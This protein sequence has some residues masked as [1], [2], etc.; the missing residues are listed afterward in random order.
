MK[1]KVN[2]CFSW[3]LMVVWPQP[4]ILDSLIP[5]Y[6]LWY[7]KT[8]IM[9]KTDK[10][11]KE[12]AQRTAKKMGIPFSAMLNESMREFV[13]KQQITFRTFEDVEDEIWLGK[14]LKAEKAGH[15]L[16]PKESEKFLEKLR[17]KHAR[18]RSR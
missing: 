6:I 3:A 5:E 16:G 11:L 13:N 2:H 1:G 12:A 10:K 18:A 8:T 4:V 14:T 9:F 15:Y 7:M 17:Q